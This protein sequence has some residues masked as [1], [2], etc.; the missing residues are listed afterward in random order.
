[1][2]IVS[3]EAFSLDIP[4]SSRSSLPA[5]RGRDHGALEALYVRVET[6]DGIVGWGESFAYNC[7][8]P[9]KVALETML[10][11]MF[12]GRD[13]RNITG[14][15]HEA[16]RVLHL[17]GRYGILNFALSGLDIALWDIAAKR[18]GMRLG[19]LIGGIARETVDSYASLYRFGEADLVAQAADK[20]RQDGY[21]RAK[22]H[23][24][25]VADF[26]AAREAV[27]SELGLMV[28]TN[29]AW[30]VSQS[31]EFTRQLMEFAPL[32]IEEPLYPPEDFATLSMLRR[33]GIPIA[34]GE[35]ACTAHEFQKIFLAAAATYAQPS[36]TKVGGITEFRKVVHL[37]EVNGVTLAPHSPY[38]GPGFLATMHLIAS[39]PEP[40]FIEY[41]NIGMAGMPYGGDVAP[42]DGAFEVPEAPGLGFDPDE[43]FLSEFAVAD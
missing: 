22:V 11:P 35:N 14:L 34:L 33:S 4:F 24:R 32:W 5:W 16:Q 3:I 1:M 31:F 27:G 15:L 18:A 19:D 6:A 40:C 26:R 8:A 29:C 43:G 41:F 36:V 37:A 13:S 10:K 23:T 2:N 25:A 17:Y 7:R 9:V 20:A 21:K 12:I 28:D 42:V 39:Q 30:T 38:F